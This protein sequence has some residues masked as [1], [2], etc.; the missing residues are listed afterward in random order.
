MLR[1]IIWESSLNLDQTQLSVLSPSDRDRYMD[2]ESLFRS[3]GWKIVKALAEQNAL[4]AHNV[5]ATANT[6]A[7]NRIAVGN[8]SAWQTIINFE[9]ATEAHYLGLITAVQATR[10]VE[11][12]HEEH[13]YE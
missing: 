8:R 2:L 12:M 9:E 1:L 4:T 13:D 10:E 3:K 6:W 7:D 5:A 11:L